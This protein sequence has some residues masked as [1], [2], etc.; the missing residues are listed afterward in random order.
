MHKDEEKLGK[1]GALLH[2]AWAKG[3]DASCIVGK[4]AED[5]SPYNVAVPSQ[6]RDQ[7]VWMQNVLHR[8][9]TKYTTA[10]T[11]YQLARKNLTDI[12]WVD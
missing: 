4:W 5:G 3:I 9:Y 10:S 2:E 12:L 6:L 1:A 8:L 11:A 7:I